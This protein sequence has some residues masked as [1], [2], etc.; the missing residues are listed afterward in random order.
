MPRVKA[1]VSRRF[2]VFLSEHVMPYQSALYDGADELIKR[3]FEDE[4]S[5]FELS[6]AVVKV[7][8]F[9]RISIPIRF[10]SQ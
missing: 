4:K 6:V 10:D 2:N 9:S 1:I 3:S 8:V 5:R 7:N